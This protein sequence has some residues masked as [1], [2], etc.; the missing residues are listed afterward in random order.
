MTNL[1]RG[2][3]HIAGNFCWCKLSRRDE[4]NMPSYNNIMACQPFRRNL[5]RFYFRVTERDHAPHHSR[6]YIR[7]FSGMTSLFCRLF[8]F[9]Q[10][11]SFVAADLSAK[12][13]KVCMCK[14][15]AIYL[16]CDALKRK[17]VCSLD[18]GTGTRNW[19]LTFGEFNLAANNYYVCMGTVQARETSSLV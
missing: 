3:Y 1:E 9:S 15:P 12:N 14:L 2:M 16:Q 10:F 8:K 7:C 11:F 18:K 17:V 19:I 13:A 5:R 6:M 4:P